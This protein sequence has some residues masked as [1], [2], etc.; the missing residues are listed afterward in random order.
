M[1]FK[2]NENVILESYL[3]IRNNYYYVMALL[4]YRITDNSCFIYLKITER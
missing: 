2:K 1:L 4:Y 3:F